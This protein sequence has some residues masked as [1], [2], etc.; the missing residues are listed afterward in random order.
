MPT[1]TPRE[2]LMFV[3]NLKFKGTLQEKIAKVND[4][5]RAFK[6]ENCSETMIGGI[7]IKGIYI[8]LLLLYDYYYMII[9]LLLL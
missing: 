7:T 1:L 8:L 2:C 3:A 5:L 9:I 4:T 6:L